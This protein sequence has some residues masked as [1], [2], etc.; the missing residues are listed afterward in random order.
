MADPTET[1]VVAEPEASATLKNFGDLDE[2]FDKV[3]PSTAE[4]RSDD[5]T[6]IA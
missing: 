3:F 1:V 6:R 2:V 4:E 5:R